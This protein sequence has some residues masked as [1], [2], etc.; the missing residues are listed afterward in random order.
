MLHC[1]LC[2][3]DFPDET[4]MVTP[5]RESSHICVACSESPL[6]RRLMA[7]EGQRYDG[8][9]PG[10]FVK[11]DRHRQAMRKALRLPRL[12]YRDE[13]VVKKRP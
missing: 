2:R 13:S 3:N 10:S 1:W 4:R 9:Y 7:R 8:Y 11:G 12:K 5:P 6:G